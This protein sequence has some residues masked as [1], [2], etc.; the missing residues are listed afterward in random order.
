MPI[1]SIKITENITDTE[2]T[3]FYQKHKENYISPE[4]RFIKY[5]IITPDNFAD[6]IIINQQELEQKIKESLEAKKNE[7]IRDLYN[8]TCSNK[9]DIDKIFE[10]LKTVNLKNKK[11]EI[12]A[13]LVNYKDC[14]A[15]EMNNKKR[16]FAR[17]F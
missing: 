15:I 16:K 12:Q 2:L 11:E 10:K 5:T 13:I 7:E 8:I 4:S 1:N 9:D 3:D 6:K 14:T 17:K